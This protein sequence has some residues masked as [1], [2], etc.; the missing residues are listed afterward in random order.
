MSEPEYI[1]HEKNE[2]QRYS[3]I[4]SA[5]TDEFR[6]VA[7]DADLLEFEIYEEDCGEPR[8][9]LLDL[10]GENRLYALLAK[11]HCSRRSLPK[12]EFATLQTEGRCFTEEH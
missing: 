6:A 12:M 5:M 1:F 8:S 9:F 3:G 10:E 7:T 11:R 2:V 4:S